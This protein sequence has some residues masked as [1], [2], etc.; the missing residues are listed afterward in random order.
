MVAAFGQI[1]RKELLDSLLCVNVHGSLLPAYRGAA[2][3]E[4]A[5]A[6]GETHTGVTIMRVTERLDSGPWA[7]RT[8][9]VGQP[10][11]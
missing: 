9:L 8:S 3:I 6:A 7:L 4:R 10:A 2:P 5:L 1:L 11:R